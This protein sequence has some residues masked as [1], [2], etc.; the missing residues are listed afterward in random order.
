MAR[1][2]VNAPRSIHDGPAPVPSGTNRRKLIAGALAVAALAAA[3]ATG[4]TARN[5]DGD[6]NP[7]G[8]ETNGDGVAQGATDIGDALVL[9]DGWSMANT[10][11]RTINVTVDGSPRSVTFE[12]A[13]T[14]D[15][16]EV[17]RRNA[18]E[19]ADIYARMVT[20][21]P[22]LACTADGCTAA[23][24]AVD[25]DI[26]AGPAAA[27]GG[28]GPMYEAAGIETALWVGRFTTIGVAAAEISFDDAITPVLFDL[29]FD[30]GV[31]SQGA[32][33]P[34]GVPTG[35]G[36][37]IA[38]GSAFGHLFPLTPS[39]RWQAPLPDVDPAGNPV[40]GPDERIEPDHFMPAA[41]LELFT[42]TDLPATS[43][44]LDGLAADVPAAAAMSPLTLT[45]LSSP[46]TG[47]GPVAVC[48]PTVADVTVTE[49]VTSAVVCDTVAGEIDGAA[50]P[51]GALL[52]TITVDG[53]VPRPP[54]GPSAAPVELVTGPVTSRSVWFFDGTLAVLGGLPGARDGI[55]DVD[56]LAS[57]S[58]G[59]FVACDGGTGSPVPG[60]DDVTP[61]VFDGTDLIT[62]APEDQDL[63]VI[64]ADDDTQP[65]P[66]PAG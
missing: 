5:G 8:T 57:V 61:P 44:F 21:A 64:H 49:T 23:G 35:N 40:G 33:N 47:C 25:A 42:D 3:F 4:V 58:D 9:V 54:L 19:F 41:T 63:G 18:E 39:S 53:A 10:A 29:T 14:V 36:G 43:P 22:D 26:L 7:Q 62:P 2:N 16:D 17:L 50:H 55:W 15:I 13:T 48:A 59:R 60:D 28:Y 32:P 27:I 66:P 52:S 31:A 56:A 24:E 1:S 45:N 38:I 46:T 34:E 12:P 11:D 20:G 37:V 6:T 51:V 65:V 30:D